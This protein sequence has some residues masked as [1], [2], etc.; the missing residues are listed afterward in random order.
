MKP[1]LAIL[2][3]TIVGREHFLSRL[4][5]ILKPQ[6]EKYNDD[7]ELIVEGDNRDMT[8]GAKRNLLTD[9]AV[10]CGATHR[11]FADDDDTVTDDYLDLNIPGVYG[12]YDCNS[13]VGIYSLNGNINPKKHVFIHSIKYSNWYEDDTNY[14]RNPNHLNC[15]K[16][17]LIKDIRFPES[18]FGED[19][20]WSER[21]HSANVL[22]NEYE[23]TKPFYN[24]LSRTKVNGI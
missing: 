17:D 22:K 6:I 21:L 8:I 1:K 5:S 9:K 7:I 20:V 15:I 23:I 12:N 24:Y 3:P 19:G 14:F 13:L 11:I 10:N 16:L 18:N 4:L 2:I